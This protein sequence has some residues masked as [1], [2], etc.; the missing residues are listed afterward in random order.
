MAAG[1]TSANFLKLSEGA[2]PSG[3]G[4]AFVGVA[5]DVNAVYWN[6]AGL[7]QLSRNQVCFMHSAWLMDV[8]FDYLAY[9]FPVA[10]FGTLAAYGVFV[11]G[12]TL[13]QTS[14]NSLGEYILTDNS[15]SAND[16]DITLAYSKKLSDILDAGNGF[17]DLSVGISANIISEKI[18][19]DSGGGFGVNLGAFYYPKFDNYS[20]GFVAENLG[21]ASKRPSLPVDLKLGFGYR[22]SMDNLMLPFSDEGTF[23]YSENDTTAALDMIYYPIEQSAEVH[24][25]AEKYWTL[26]KFHAI[27]LRLGYKFGED[28]GALAGI[29]AGLGYR[30][31]ASK[32]V[33]VD[34]DYVIV[35]YADLGNSN[36][37]SITGKFMGTSEKHFFEDRKAAIAAYKR[38]YD[39][40][41]K[42][43]FQDAIPDFAECVKKYRDY[44]PAYMGLGACFLN[45]GR[46]QLAFMAY[47][48]A[49]ELDPSN[50][51]LKQWIDTN[52]AMQNPA[53]AAR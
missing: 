37:I 4:E 36:R 42:M 41:Y 20:V 22:F 38:G 47:S 49:L 48:K 29:T 39:R 43:D 34:I 35:P 18:V 45:T 44:A 25:G 30:L 50:V 28:L 26:N 1:E 40:L 3:M 17:S 52:Q 7:S 32:D 27:A 6:P 23:V 12:G 21:V 9:A 14:E 31:T 16:F 33:N 8:N 46:R 19:S 5:D 51:K 15:V 11:N 53:P 2:R 10:G 13:T 24:I